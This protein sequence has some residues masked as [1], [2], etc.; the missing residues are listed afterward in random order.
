MGEITVYHRIKSQYLL[1]RKNVKNHNIVVCCDYIL[2]LPLWHFPPLVSNLYM[3]MHAGVCLCVCVCVCVCVSVCVCVCM[4]LCV[5]DRVIHIE[6]NRTKLGGGQEI[7]K[8]E[9]IM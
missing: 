5:S 3:C 1:Y 4:V 2:S 6:N 8:Y 7:S 9:D